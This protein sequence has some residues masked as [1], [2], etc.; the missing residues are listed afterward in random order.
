[1]VGIKMD[2]LKYMDRIEDKIGQK[3]EGTD[4]ESLRSLGLM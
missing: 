1:L 2:F 3:F 4:K